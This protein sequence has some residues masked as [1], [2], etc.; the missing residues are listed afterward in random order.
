MDNQLIVVMTRV[1]YRKKV[2]SNLKLYALGRP[3]SITYF[4]Y[5]HRHTEPSWF[6][7]KP[8]LQSSKG[9]LKEDIFEFQI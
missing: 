2:T 5:C 3:K 6:L 1:F 9:T 4:F 8:L 7:L